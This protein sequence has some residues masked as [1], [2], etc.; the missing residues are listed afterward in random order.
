MFQRMNVAGMTPVIPAIS[1]VLALVGVVLFI[2]LDR[3]VG[4]YRFLAGRD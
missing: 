1:F 4:V 2:V 3:T